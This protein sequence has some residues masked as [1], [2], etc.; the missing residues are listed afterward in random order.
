M[1]RHRRSVFA[2]GPVTTPDQ[3]HASVECDGR[4][5]HKVDHRR[6]TDYATTKIIKRACN[7]AVFNDFGEVNACDRIV[8]DERI[9][10][11]RK[12]KRSV[13]QSTQNKANR[14]V[15]GQ[16]RRNHP[17]RDHGQTNKPVA[18]VSRENQSRIN[19]AFC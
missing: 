3:H 16:E 17:D 15:A 5:Q 10:Q 19:A 14:Q 11:R 6:S 13:E 2:T 8:T 1:P 4:H 9:G 7:A 12:R 18:Q